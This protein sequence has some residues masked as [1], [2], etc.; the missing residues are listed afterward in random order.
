MLGNQLRLANLSIH[1]LAHFGEIGLGI[2][3]HHRDLF[4]VGNKHLF[5]C[6]KNVIELGKMFGGSNQNQ[7]G[8]YL[9]T[10]GN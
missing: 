8:I 10:E 7:V 6:P 1:E 4:A 5:L 2:Y 9:F 3:A